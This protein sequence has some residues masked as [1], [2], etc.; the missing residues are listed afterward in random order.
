V[1]LQAGELSFIWIL[2]WGAR[3]QRP[4]QVAVAPV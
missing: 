3:D 2:I 1:I 4:N